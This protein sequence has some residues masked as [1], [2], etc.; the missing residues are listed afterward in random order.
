MSTLS[1]QDY[2]R[3]RMLRRRH[4]SN[5]TPAPSPAEMPAPAPEP[6]ERAPRPILTQRIAVDF[7]AQAKRPAPTRKAA[8]TLPTPSV[9]KGVMD[10]LQAMKELIEDRFNTLTWLG[11]AKQ[12]PIQSNLMLKMIRSGYS[13]TL[14]RAILER[15]PEEM[16]ATE[17]VRWVM[18]VLERNVRTD[19]DMPAI[20]EEG[21]VF[22][23]IG[24]TGVGKITDCP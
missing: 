21:G 23:L 12:N 15:L 17:A 13:P 24:A 14:S 19:A 10:E 2:V 5:Q 20:H 11:Q 6:V 18:E 16:D 8:V 1:F 4:E 9:N 22:A 3:E 7:E